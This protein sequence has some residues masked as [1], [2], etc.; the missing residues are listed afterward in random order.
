MSGLN[1]VAT[2]GN[3]PIII[4]AHMHFSH[5][6]AFYTAAAESGAQYS[7]EGYLKE[8]EEAGI[9][10]GVCMGLAEATPHAFPDK[11]A[12]V[13]MG[14]GMPSDKESPMCAGVPANKEF[15]MGAGVP[16][17]KEFLMGAGVPANKND[18]DSSAHD[19]KV[20]PAMYTCLGINP[21]GLNEDACNRIRA[22]IKSD[23]T[24]VG[25]K[26]YAGYYHY[27][28][29]DPI[30]A[31]VYEI[32]AEHN[33]TVAIHTGVTYSEQGIMDY[34]HPLTADRA[35]VAYRDT[36]FLLCHMGNPWIM[37]G[38]EVAY[39]NRNVFLDISG[40]VEGNAALLDFTESQPLLMQHYMTGL[41]YLNNYKKVLFGTDWP[42][43]P[44]ARYI[45]FCKKLIPEHAWGDVF[46][47][48]AKRVYRCTS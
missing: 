32:A 2:R 6:Q 11:N 20:P 5:I 29:H 23:P 7:Y 21:H 28:V 22:R 42:I 12:E 31:P 34:S 48:N 10:A 24:V 45:E 9:I 39:K 13:P 44:M 35:A 41:V 46:Y 3:A 4:D 40:L 16:A 17:D 26:I 36:R 27:F 15:L 1:T 25:F 8:R 38:C 33:L 43:V 14:A 30:Y 18:A 19:W 47:E 37:D